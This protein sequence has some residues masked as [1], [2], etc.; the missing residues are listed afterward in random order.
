MTPSA[1]HQ[2]I[3]S[4]LLITHSWISNQ[5]SAV[6]VLFHISRRFSRFQLLIMAPGSPAEINNPI[7]GYS[8]VSDNSE[9]LL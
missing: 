6:H 5:R 8:N 4:L 7:Q 2:L 1:D 9:N 3:N